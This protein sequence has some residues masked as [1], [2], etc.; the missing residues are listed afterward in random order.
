[1]DGS[2]KL[3]ADFSLQGGH[4][5]W[6]KLSSAQLGIWLGQ[7]F[8]PSATMYWC[9]EAYLLRGALDLSRLQEAI[10]TCLSG[11]RSLHQEFRLDEQ[12][13]VW[14]TQ[15]RHAMV[16][17]SDLVPLQDCADLAQARAWIAEDLQSVADLNAGAPLFASRMLRLGAQEVLWY[18]RIHHIAADG[19]SFA[20][21]AQQAASLYNAGRQASARGTEEAAA[22]NWRRMLAEDVAYQH[23][24]VRER[25]QRFWL[26]YLHGAQTALLAPPRPAACPALTSV[27]PPPQGSLALTAWQEMAR[28]AKLDWSA[29][30]MAAFAAWLQRRC[31]AGE[32]VLGLPVMG[33][34]GSA[35]LDLPCMW[36]NI[37]PLRLRF[38]PQLSLQEL[39][40]QVAQEM[41][42]IRPHQRYRYEHLKQDLQLHAEARLFGAVLNIMPFA[43]VPQFAAVHSEMWPLAAGPVEDLAFNLRLQQGTQNSG[44]VLEWQLQAN[45]LAYAADQL[46][47]LHTDLERS[48]QALAAAPSTP[49]A[50]VLGLHPRHIPAL[51]QGPQLLAGTGLP[52]LEML[53]QQVAQQPQAIA[54]QHQGQELS[55]AQL[56]L[57]VQQLAAHLRARHVGENRRV[58]LLLPRSPQAVVAMLAVLWAGGAY[59]P[60]DTEGPPLRTQLVLQDANP[61]LL[62][63]LRS[64]VRQVPPTMPLLC[65]DQ[66]GLPELPPL[67]E[68]VP[69]AA[70]ALAYLIYTSGSTGK[71]NGVMIARTA[72]SH[73]VAAAGQRYAINRAD[74]VLQ[75]APLHFDASVEEIW[76]SLCFGARLVLRDSAMLAGMPEFL[77]ACTRLQITVLDLPTAFWH[78]LCFYL[79]AAG[80]DAVPLPPGL[81]LVIIGG[82]AAQEARL[83][84]WRKHAPSQLRLLNT[85][86]PTEATVIC[87][88]AELTGPNADAD[89]G[90]HI[91]QP[92]PGLEIRIVEEG[93][94]RILG[95][96]E[97]GELCILGPSL[98]LGYSG[99]AAL[100]AQ[101]FVEFNRYDEFLRAYRSGDRAMVD[102]QGRLHYLGRLDQECKLAG[103]RID[104]LEVENHLL[105]HPAVKAALVIL[106][107]SGQLLALLELKQGS[108]QDK[109]EFPQVQP[110]SSALAQEIRS[111]LQQNLPA[112]A[113]PSLLYFCRQIPRN[114]NGKLDRGQVGKLN[115]ELAQA[116]DGD[117]STEQG[118]DALQDML[119]QMQ[120]PWE[121]VF[122]RP[123][124]LYDADFFALGGASLQALQL[125]SRLSLQLQRRIGVQM[126]MQYP[127]ARALAQALLESPALAKGSDYFAPLLCLQSAAT[128]RPALFCLPPA[129]G[130]GWAYMG[131]TRYLP[132]WPVYALQ[133]QGWQTG[134]EAALDIEQQLAAY[135]HTI[136]QQQA[137][138][139][140]FLLGWSSG[141][142]MA[143]ALASR[144]QQAGQEVGCLVLLDAY[145][146]H[147][148]QDSPPAQ[149]A[150]A[151]DALRD[152][153]PPAVQSALASQVRTGLETLEQEW[154][155]LRRQLQAAA[156]P[157]AEL[158]A[159]RLQHILQVICQ[160]M[161]AYRGLQHHPFTGHT[162]FFHADAGFTLADML[163]GQEGSCVARAA[164]Q[165]ATPASWRDS[166]SADTEYLPIKANHYQ[167]CRAQTL[168]QLGPVLQAGL[169]KRL[170]DRFK[171]EMASAEEKKYGTR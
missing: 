4:R 11:T 65:L 43:Q 123:L 117:A 62:L 22:E 168:A 110:V 84:V 39:A 104:P 122:A 55:Y 165:R 47:A 99:R 60:L 148:W 53:R 37:V 56:L 30:L 154:P 109:A 124:K 121:Q 159:K 27:L 128:Q 61:C 63:C 35:S 33:R 100:T 151:F 82:E 67:L 132:G 66:P 95:R 144:L 88:S 142:G 134:T 13:Q 75:F 152:A 54:L 136:C 157:L 119:Q 2:S 24:P 1:M 143:Q 79:G 138:G 68:P 146:A 102:E 133:A 59:L 153:F 116:A 145:P 160:G 155:Q 8:D 20:L 9:A 94:S 34:L 46:Q 161:Q 131:L 83:A 6:E 170:P 26:D 130:L 73:F 127:Q 25:D 97:A 15:A 40:M 32:L 76:L 129:E 137:Q 72:L 45:P 92:L 162:L 166:L 139:P 120:T 106:H 49:L 12:G 69:V 150:D 93:G 48:L 86:G 81:R 90:A 149:I 169:T 111:F 98:A 125:A 96:G 52:V 107:H 21:L 28:A 140:Y 126:I 36:M 19:F 31:G 78:E 114:P 135:M 14:Q 57:E 70:H 17:S 101:R 29:C 71:P 50:Q 51:L 3:A 89:G 147:I 118:D 141:G 87:S 41:R 167:F 158:D 103:H 5:E 10:S 113:L 112:P 156:S 44:G 163:R 23:G 16:N 18:L 77:Q 171:H 80:L 38:T 164:A 91:G 42:R 7:Q 58:A 85:Y 108:S 105:Q 74:R 115:L 64:H